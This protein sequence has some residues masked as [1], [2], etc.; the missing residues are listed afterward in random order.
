M[1]IRRRA[2]G[3]EE[4]GQTVRRHAGVHRAAAGQAASTV[5]PR[6]AGWVHEIKFDGYRMQLRIEAGRA[7]LRT[8]KGLDWTARF[9][10]IAEAGERLPDAIID[11]EIVALDAQRRARLRGLQAALSDGKTDDLIFF[12]FDLLFEGGEDLRDAAAERAQGAAEGAARAEGAEPPPLCRTLH[13][14]RRGGAELGLPHVAGRDR[15]QA[16]RRAL[17]LGPRRNL[18]EVQ[19]P[20]RP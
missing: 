17:S 2:S 8:R 20:R 9:P 11:G 15:L 13:Q 7:V 3:R 16:A 5:R 14:R 4:A 10:D 12:V 1:P 18:A 19:M 6:G